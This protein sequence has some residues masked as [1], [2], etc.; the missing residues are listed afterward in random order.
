MFLMFHHDLRKIMIVMTLSVVLVLG[1]SQAVLAADYNILSWDSFTPA[2]GTKVT[3]TTVSVTAKTT[4]WDSIAAG[5]M[6]MY[7]DNSLVS[8]QSTLTDGEGGGG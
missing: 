7:I 5:S 4:D 2:N 1:F 3:S 8:A 6:K